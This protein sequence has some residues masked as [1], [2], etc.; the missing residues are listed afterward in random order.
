VFGL[1]VAVVNYTIR[2]LKEHMGVEMDLAIPARRDMKTEVLGANYILQIPDLF[3]GIHQSSTDN[4]L[5]CLGSV[6]N[7]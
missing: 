4:S 3:W 5:P 6:I 7:T 2:A 1:Q